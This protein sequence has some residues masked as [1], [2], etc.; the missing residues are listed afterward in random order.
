MKFLKII[1]L[2]VVITSCSRSNEPISYV[3]PFIGTGAHGHTF[4]GA[5]T[6][7]GMVQLSPDTR[8]GN[9]DACSGYHYSD[10]IIIGFSHTHLSG[11]GCI[12]LGDVLIRPT[13]QPLSSFIDMEG[14]LIPAPF[15]HEREIARPGY[16][17]VMLDEE[18]IKCELTA[19]KRAGIHR[20][21]FP[22]GAKPGIILDLSHQLDNEQIELRI[23]S[24]SKNEI[25][26]YRF[27]KGWANDQRL[28][29]VARFSQDF[30]NTIIWSKG[31]ALES[32]LPVNSDDIK[33]ELSWDD[34]TSSEI[35]VHVGISSVSIAGAKKNLETEAP[36]F[37]FE[38]Y[39]LQAEKLWNKELAMIR[40]KGGTQKE[41]EIFY[42]ALYHSLIAPYIINDVDGSYRGL[43]GEIH[44]DEK[45]NHYTAF[46]LWDTFRAWH[47][48]MTFRDEAFVN[49]MINSMLDFYR[50]S[51]ELP[52]W[53]LWG[54][55]T[56][57]M[58]GYH[59][60]SVIADAWKKGIRGY[61]AELALEAMIAS[62]NTRRKGNDLYRK[63]GFIPANMKRESVSCLL[64]YAYD[65]W[66]VSLLAE[67]LGKEEIA[68]EYKTR[69]LNYR[70][71]FDGNSLFFRGKQDNGNWI[72]PFDPFEVSRDMTEANAWQ[73][74]FFVPHDI[75]G[76][77][78]L[79]GGEKAFSEALDT[80]FNVTSEIKGDLQDITGLVGQYA[81]GNEPSHHISHLYSYVGQPWKTQLYVHKLLNEMYDNT[82]GGII[83]NEDCGQM[84]AWYLMNSLGIYPVCPGS[85]E[86]ILTTPRFE[87]MIFTLGNGK[88]IR[89]ET[90]KDPHKYPFI[91]SVSWNGEKVNATFITHQQLSSGGVLS[92]EL[93]QEAY[94]EAQNSRPYSMTTEKQVSNPYL[95]SDVSFFLDSCV[96]E[97]GV[98]TAGAAVY[99]TLDGTEPAITSEKYSK[100][101]TLRE[102]KTIKI[103]AFKDG[104]RASPVSTIEATKATLALS[105]HKTLEQNGVRYNYFEGTF[106]KVADMENL[107]PVKKGWAENISLELAE[108]EDHYG[109]T[110]ESF[111]L[112][113]ADGLY[114][115]YTISDDGSVLWVDGKKVVD[116]DGSHAAVKATGLIG[117]K[118]GVHKID[119]H[120]IEDYEGQLLEVGMGKKE[121][122]AKPFRD[123]E[124]WR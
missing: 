101:F 32:V 76:L 72:S 113:P 4:P 34:L 46:S 80:L 38:E 98:A 61:D 1:L 64:E 91:K 24:I 15:S 27:S 86:Y 77:V 87:E 29:F 56:N 47:P 118:K 23:Q 62:S 42:T 30:Q 71:V 114:E 28:Y 117:L 49:E 6:P 124:L 67:D 100:P 104:M 3:N 96:V 105:L 19:T 44:R 111:I 69:A 57:T 106:S 10:S 121:Q 93:S 7:F 35:E 94:K 103:K 65:D 60:V 59:S 116:N 89:I 84:S 120:Y 122:I 81:H 82:P 17:N 123:D 2:V 78:N 110:F 70:N 74:R 11:T 21:T 14:K 5:T 41:K 53:P 75:Q 73:Y 8:T 85:N 66:C 109:F 18:H 58:I 22:E 40:V 99:F 20:Y 97:M 88:Q 48:L 36:S 45:Q 9:W 33:V 63:L 50:Q 108:Q 26:G 112:V 83:G 55:E 43:D 92:F 102:S 90:D 16:Y 39:R 54:C 37:N 119:V 31:K 52:V 107:M 115:F 95:E 79:F 13:T 68:N 51:G 25:S 12:D